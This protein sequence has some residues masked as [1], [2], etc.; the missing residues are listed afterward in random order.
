M[1]AQVL[2]TQWK[3]AR[4]ELLLY[5]LAGFLIPTM[6]IRIGLAYTEAYSELY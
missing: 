5:V 6:I 4:T 2:Y 3:W 1:F